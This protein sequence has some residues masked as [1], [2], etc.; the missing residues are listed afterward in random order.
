[1]GSLQ[2]IFRAYAFLHLPG[3]AQKNNPSYGLTPLLLA[4]TGQ[5]HL[6]IIPIGD[7]DVEGDFWVIPFEELS[8]WLVSENL[9]KGETRHGVSRIPRWRFHI[10]NPQLL[11]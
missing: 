1:M 4:K 2:F 6:R 5:E 3:Q 8:R 9:T 10:E 11:T 7:S